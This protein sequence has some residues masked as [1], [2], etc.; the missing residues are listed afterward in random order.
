[1][2][3]SVPCEL[4][5]LNIIRGMVYLMSSGTYVC[6]DCKEELDRIEPIEFDGTATD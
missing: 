6:R 1:M 5:Q 3:K 4:C 2:Q